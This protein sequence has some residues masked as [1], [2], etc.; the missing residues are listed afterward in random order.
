MQ[1]ALRFVENDFDI[2][3]RYFQNDYLENSKLTTSW[4]CK[5]RFDFSVNNQFL[6][7]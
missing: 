1:Q 4:I 3:G 5:K 7:D 6:I 2:V